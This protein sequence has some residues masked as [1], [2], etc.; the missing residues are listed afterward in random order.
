ME[1]ALRSDGAEGATVLGPGTEFEGLLTFRGELRVEGV[2]A[3][4]V[5][6]Q[7]RLV[8]APGARVRARVSVDEL[9]LGGEFQ[10]DVDARQRVEL[11]ATGRLAG[12]VHA[13]RLCVQDGAR[14]D[15]RCRTGPQAAVPAAPPGPKPPRAP[16]PPAPAGSG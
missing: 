5:T 9:V 7:G 12:T 2:L 11:L 3:G 16:S 4:E 6:A 1:R 13:P 8:I 14:L 10:G 15:G